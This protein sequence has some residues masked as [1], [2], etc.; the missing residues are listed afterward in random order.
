MRAE[1]ATVVG[2]LLISCAASAQGG[3]AG[4]GVAG[5]DVSERKGNAAIESLHLTSEQQTNLE[6]ALRQHDYQKAEVLLVGE[7]NRD[8]KSPAAASRFVFVGHLF[9]LDAQYLNAAIAWKKADALQP[10]HQRD[11]FTLAMAYIKLKQEKWAREELETLRKGYPRN[12]LYLYWLGRLDYD[13]RAYHEAIAKFQEVVRL[14]PKMMRAYDNL[15]LCYDY[16]GRYPEAV[17]NYS[18]AIEL[19]RAQAAPSPW[20]HL[21]LGLALMALN[22]FDEAESQFEEAIHYDANFAHAHYHLGQVL[23]KKDELEKAVREFQDAIRLDPSYAEPHYALG[24]LDQRL[25][26]HDDAQ[27]EIKK[28][29][30]LQRGEQSDLQRPQPS[31]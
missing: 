11:R 12:T 25:G 16:L 13:A 28:F 14:D 24:K 10:L 26:K 2:V 31:K 20:P 23:Q 6:N 30:E 18:R 8:P 19:N 9:F 4:D 17:E 3:S 7:T 29:Q 27:Q 15:G 22:R 21:N 5:S 1:I